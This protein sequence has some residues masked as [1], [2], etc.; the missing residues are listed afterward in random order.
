MNEFIDVKGFVM[1]P[2]PTYLSFFLI[3]IDF[4]QFPVTLAKH[5]GSRLTHSVAP[6]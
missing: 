4:T 2:V 1:F 5:H 6:L 3:S